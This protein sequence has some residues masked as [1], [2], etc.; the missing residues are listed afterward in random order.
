M[1]RL[2]YSSLYMDA[3]A[4][5]REILLG[6]LADTDAVDAADAETEAADEDPP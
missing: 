5:W 1:L 6:S 4:C 2:S 3:D